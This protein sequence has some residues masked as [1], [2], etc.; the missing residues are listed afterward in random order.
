MPVATSRQGGS[1]PFWSALIIVIDMVALCARPAKAWAPAT[2]LYP[3]SVRF[4][5][6][7]CRDCGG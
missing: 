5:S 3:V 6:F 2:S 1:L 4:Y 7:A